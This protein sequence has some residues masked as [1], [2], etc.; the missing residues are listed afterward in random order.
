MEERADGFNSKP[1]MTTPRYGEALQWAEELHRQQRRKG[2]PIPY[3]AH[4]IRVSALVWED[5]GSED[6]AIAALLH[7]AIEDAGQTHASIAERFG[8]TVADIVRDCTDTTPETKTGR[9]GTLTAAQNPPPRL[10]STSLLKLTYISSPSE[11]RPNCSTDIES[12]D[13]S[14]LA[15]LNP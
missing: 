4:L 3:I 9:E 8:V 11:D 10:S 7:D 6:Q 1:V 14:H 12:S 13:I 15:S 5:D 2:K